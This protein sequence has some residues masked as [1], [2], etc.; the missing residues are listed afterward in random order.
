MF[1]VFKY[2][3]FVNAT[4]YKNGKELKNPLIAFGSLCP[5]KRFA[6]LQLKWFILNT[7]LRFSFTL[8]DAKPAEYATEYHGHEILPPVQDIDVEFHP[9]EDVPHLVY[10]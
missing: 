4:F 7:M 5:G 1:Q 6:I 9:N 8:K 2:D 3:R 10:Q